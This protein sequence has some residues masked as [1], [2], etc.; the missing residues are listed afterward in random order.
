MQVF[1]EAGVDDFIESICP[2]IG[3]SADFVAYAFG[4]AAGGEGPNGVAKNALGITDLF[5]ALSRDVAE[6]PSASR[7]A[8][9]AYY[10]LLKRDD[11]FVIPLGLAL[12]AHHAARDELHGPRCSALVLVGLPNGGRSQSPGVR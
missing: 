5:N 11:P 1:K 7:A 8:E 12:T 3:Q 6:V 10:L 2:R 4:L 9:S